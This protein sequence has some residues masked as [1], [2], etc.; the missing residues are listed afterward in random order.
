MTVHLISI[1][2]SPI[3]ELGCLIVIFSLYYMTFNRILYYLR[4]SVSQGGGIRKAKRVS[5]VAAMGTP[6]P[7]PPYSPAPGYG[8]GYPPAGPP[9]AYQEGI[10]LDNTQD[11]GAPVPNTSKYTL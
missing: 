1:G 2:K 10:Q 9:P 5:D 8:P 11:F 3:N 4:V 7:A 6:S